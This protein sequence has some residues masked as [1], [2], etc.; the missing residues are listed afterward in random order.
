[1]SP[2]VLARLR[3]V[4]T[5]AFAAGVTFGSMLG[6]PALLV[7]LAS[8]FFA[9]ELE[10]VG[11]VVLLLAVSTFIGAVVAAWVLIFKARS[12]LKRAEQALYAGDFDSATQNAQFVLKTVFRADY[13]M[14]ALFTLA[15]AAERI[16]AFAEAGALFERALAMI[17]TFAAMLPGRR[18][19]ALLTAHAAIAFA[20]ANDLSRANAMLSRCHAELGATGQPGALETLILDDSSFGAIG[21]NTMLAE[22]ENRREPRPLGVLASLVVTFKNGRPEQAIQL[23]EYTRGVE[24]GLA[25]HERALAERVRSEAAR[26][27]AGGGPHRAP[28]ALVPPAQDVPA[29]W[30]AMIL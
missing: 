16:G 24:H 14:G 10:I 4:P 2:V 29:A 7:A 3:N 21:V 8:A 19:R 6:V 20:A 22:L 9:V 15:L 26:A 30:A 13:Q 1:M 27:L 11:V 25:P 23:Y 17:P 18:A 5:R 12:G 28:S